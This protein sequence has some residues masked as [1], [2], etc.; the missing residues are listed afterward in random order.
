MFL[1]FKFLDS[2]CLSC[3]FKCWCFIWPRA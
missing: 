2:Q 3:Y 1:D